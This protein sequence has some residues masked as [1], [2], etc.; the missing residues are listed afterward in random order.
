MITITNLSMTFGA[1]LLF[2]EVNLNLLSGKRYGLVGANGTGK[3]TFMKLL[4]HEEEPALGEITFSHNARIGWLKQDQF[5]YEDDKIINAVLRGKPELWSALQE[6]ER[7]IL[8]DVWTEETGFRLGELEEIIAEQEGYTA[9]TLAEKLLLGLGIP[10]KEHHKPLNTLS[11]G[12]KLRV[13]LAQALFNNP[14][15]LLLDEPTNHLDIMSIAWLESYLKNEFKG[16]LIFISHDH[17]FL[18]ALATHILDI[19]YGEIRLYHGN[20][21]QFLEDK[22]QILI[23][24]NQERKNLERRVAHL[25]SFVDRFRA[26]ATKARQAQSKLKMIERIE[27]PDIE[28]SSRI[29]PNFSFQIKRPSGKA[30]VNIKHLS[31]R[32]G[33]K[34]VLKNISFS[35]KRGD[36]V[37]L[38]GHNGIGKST[39]LK[40]VLDLIPRDE[41]TVEWGHETHV[42]YFAQDH[43][44]LL[45]EN[46]SAYDWLCHHGEKETTSRIRAVLGQVLFSQDEAH[47]NILTLSGGEGARLLLGKVMLEE[48]NVLILDEP[49]N[50][51]DIESIEALAKA[52]QKFDGTLIFVSHDRHFVSKVATRVIAFTENGIK[53]YLGN[54]NDYLAQYGED[55]LSREWLKIYS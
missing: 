4:A 31:K 2:D 11:G 52:L 22:Q 55:Y 46:V 5:R 20:Y 33:E 34:Q 36:K 40:T 51:L 3:S 27:F 9:E 21:A 10:A 28:K 49:T 32:F 43:H 13:L 15:V 17:N 53:D 14:D 50:H 47:K 41:G 18:N 24:K 45:K 39:L 23:Q 54:Y 1:R 35:I 44:E 37:V 6:K 29:A 26:K 42:A 16:L 7:L 48:G 19:D 25:Q 38:I 12:Y 8:N 30:V